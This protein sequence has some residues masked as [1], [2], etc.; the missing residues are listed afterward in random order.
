MG[1]S[2]MK[3]LGESLLES[4]KTGQEKR[5]AVEAA[6]DAITDVHIEIA[7]ACQEDNHYTPNLHQGILHSNLAILRELRR[8]RCT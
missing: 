7:L 5:R 2:E 6:Y 1:R 8:E 3:S 4:I